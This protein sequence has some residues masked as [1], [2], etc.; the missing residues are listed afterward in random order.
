MYT[1]F[2]H[3]KYSNFSLYNAGVGVQVS[4]QSIN[5]LLFVDDVTFIGNSEQELNTILDIMSKFADKWNLKFN[6]TKSKV[7]VVGRRIDR[8]KV[9]TL[10]DNCIHDTNEYKYLGVYV[11]RTLKSNYHVQTYIKD[12][13]DNKINFI[14]R[15]PAEHG[16]F[17]RVEFGDALWNSVL[18]PSISHCCGAWLTSSKVNEDLLSSIQ[19]RAAKIIMKTKVNMSKAALLIELRRKPISDF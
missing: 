7:M 10:C 12:N 17:N 1:Y 13:M 15:I 2:L 8:G 14:L 4:N 6:A 9:W 18:R 16:N 19:F 3:F 5:S 11:T